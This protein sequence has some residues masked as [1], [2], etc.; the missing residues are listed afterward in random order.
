[1]NNIS[2]IE[3]FINLGIR[4]WLK[5]ICSK[6]NIK[7]LKI[8]INKKFIG[9]IDEINL[10]A[11]NIIYQNIYLSKIIIKTKNCCLKFNY[12]NKIIF[13][14]N[15]MINSLL[16]IDNINLNNLLFQN[17]WENVRIKIQDVFLEG[18][19]ITN[20]TIK[21]NLINLKYE[22]NNFNLETNISLSLVNNLIFL[23]NLKNKKKMQL[24]IDENIKFNYL[25]IKNELINI[26]LTSKVIFND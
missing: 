7:S 23:E 20:I 22:K 8:N 17:K 12:K 10:E 21:K 26:D 24:P 14:E 15:L 18:H 19:N 25:K 6:I 16:I 1:M 9:K 2:V 13:A 4:T 11:V 5:S 3:N